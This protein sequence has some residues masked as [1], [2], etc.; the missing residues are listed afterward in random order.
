MDEREATGAVM[1]DIS[2]KVSEMQIMSP[3]MSKT[4]T[5][6]YA[7]G[8]RIAV[9]ASG[10]GSNF[11][12]IVDANERG[13]VSLE[14][15]LLVCNDPEAYVIER[16]RKHSIPHVVIQHKGRT[17]QEFES[18][19]GRTLREFD[20]GL[21]VLAGFMRVLSPSFV[22]EW[23]DRILNI[24]PSLLPAFPGASAQQDA[25][26]YGVKVS[27][28][29]IHYVD[30][31]VDHGPIIFQLPVKVGDDDDGATLS[32]RIL[33]EEHRWYPRVIQWVVDGRLVREGRRVRVR[34]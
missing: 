15:A 8:N 30:E 10:R 29:T 25:V 13:D 27:G 4:A 12:A 32:K 20:I 28:L 31:E 26:E 33:E 3:G 24:H 21:I 16:A 1:D 14:I 7:G 2:E 34:K 23:Q 5:R 9:L 17:R 18:I 19:L 22:L 6:T 11:Q